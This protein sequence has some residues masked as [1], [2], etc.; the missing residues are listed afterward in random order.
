[1]QNAKN[2]QKSTSTQICRAVSSQLRHVSTI[3]KKL[4]NSNMASTC[5]H[6]M[7]NFGSLTAEIGSGVWGTGH[8]MQQLQRVSRLGSFT[9][10]TSLTGGQPNFARS[11]AVS[12][13]GLVH[14]I[15]IFGGCCPLTEF[16]ILPGAKFT[17]W[18]SLAFS[19]IASV[20]ARH[21]SSGHQLNFAASYKE[22][23]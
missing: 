12:W 13:A 6:N 15:C 2:Y 21:S 20:I 17:L 11:L 16:R 7:A 4:L 1:M 9:A 22:W 10:P 23:N 3:G 19:Y 18:P 8:P 14:Y 5:F